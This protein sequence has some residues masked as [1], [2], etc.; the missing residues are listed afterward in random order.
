MLPKARGRDVPRLTSL[1]LAYVLLACIAD[2]G[3]GV[4]GQSVREFA[5]L[6]T[7]SGAVLSDVIEGWMAGTVSVSGVHSAIIQLDP[8]SVSIITGCGR[9]SYGPE[10][11]QAAAAH[12][13]TVPGDA[14]R[15][16]VAELRGATPSEADAALAA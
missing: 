1:Q 6:R 11:D 2:R 13:I 8:A 16:I 9:L 3:I 4:A 15:E 5:A 10:R 7:T 14:L 12:I